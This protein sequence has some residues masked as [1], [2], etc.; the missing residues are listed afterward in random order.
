MKWKYVG[1]WE[2]LI[3]PSVE[4]QPLL[5]TCFQTEEVNSQY[6]KDST[7]FLYKYK[8]WR[9]FPEISQVASIMMKVSLTILR[10]REREK[11]E[12]T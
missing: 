6:Y 10:E 7:I 3:S 5:C 11:K 9:M 1:H 2:N 4:I 8:I 12:N